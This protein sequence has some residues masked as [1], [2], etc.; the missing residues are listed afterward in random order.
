MNN[1]AKYLHRYAEAEVTLLKDFPSQLTFKHVVV[2]PAYKEQ[3]GFIEDFFASDLIA[4]NVL[5]ILV[6]NQPDVELDSYPQL[7]LAEYALSIGP[8]IWSEK[9]LQ[10]ILSPTCHS[11][12]L[13]VDR[14]TEAINAQWGV[15]LAR[16]VGADL[17]T[18]LIH[19]G[20]IKSSW[21][22]STDADASLP[23]NY[24]SALSAL[25][26]NVVASCF[27]FVHCSDDVVVHRANALYE[28]ALRYYVAGLRFANSPYAFFTIGSILVF[29]QS[30]YVKVRGF[31]KKNAGEDF[32]L[33]NKLAKVGDIAFLEDSLIKLQARE[34]DRVPFGTGPSVSQ[35]IALIKDN[36]AYCYYHPQVFD[37]LKTALSAFRQLYQS[38]YHIE[39]W[40]VALSSEIVVVLKFLNLDVFVAKQQDV[41]EQQFL[42]QLMV[43]FDAF[44]TLKFI[45]YC[46]DHYCPN[47]DL[48]QA[49]DIAE[50]DC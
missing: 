34:S 42:K 25:P 49:I 44:K 37:Y 1:I 14:F 19:S 7:V 27:N 39:Q 48:L 43:W 30:A 23:N 22:A 35:I 11:G 46:R 28:R 4:D 3:P 18:A 2:I 10:L 38:R 8:C 29:N 20:H 17:A 9:N 6:V 5:M 16:K 31:P 40:Y 36:K 26:T 32:Y 21:I 15:G 41:S 50:F 45:H 24:F 47:I 13:L 12:I 33:L